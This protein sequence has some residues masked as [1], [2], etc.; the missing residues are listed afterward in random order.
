MSTPV[1]LAELDLFH[2]W[3]E[4]P[5]LTGTFD[6]FTFHHRMAAYRQLIDATNHA[7]LFG[8]D[9][10]RNPLWGLMFQ[11]QWQFRSGRLGRNSRQDGHID[12]DAAWGYGNYSLNVIP[13]L[14]AVEAGTV[15]DLVIAGPSVASRFRYVSGGGAAPV[16]VPPEFEKGVADWRDYFRLVA[17]TERGTDQEPIR[18]ALWRAHRTCL[19]VV[20]TRVANI[21]PAPYTAAELAF[22]QGWCRMVLYLDAAAWPTDF[23]FMTQYG[24]DVL[25]EQ[26]LPQSDLPPRVRSNVRNVLTLARTPVWRHNLNLWM[27]RRIMR[28]RKAR[29][30]V[31]TMLDALFNPNPANTANR[32]RMI[33]YLLRP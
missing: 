7:G 27:W 6:P 9:N 25:P 5:A 26:L 15:P 23:D 4:A 3:S 21:D 30:E 2:A 17:A 10:R 22:L 8:P 33:G 1:E 20:A 14:G 24:L 28:T 29:D 13:W 32:R 19:D 12:P 16:Q 31:V 11:A 18:F